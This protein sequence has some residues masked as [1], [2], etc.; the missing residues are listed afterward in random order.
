MSQIFTSTPMEAHIQA[1]FLKAQVRVAE[2]MTS[3]NT[4]RLLLF[5]VL[6]W[7]IVL[8][9][10]KI[11]SSRQQAGEAAVKIVYR[12]GMVFL[13]LSLLNLSVPEVHWSS[14]SG[15]WGQ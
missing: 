11:A 9:F 8:Q 7:A 5:G 2:F 4:F 3:T 15:E 10:L 14:A 1:L 6:A 12:I 13:A